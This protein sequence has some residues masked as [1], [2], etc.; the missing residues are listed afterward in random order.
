MVINTI[1]DERLNLKFASCKSLYR[2]P[3]C[4]IGRPT[5]SY[6]PNHPFLLWR[7]YQTGKGW[8]MNIISSFYIYVSNSNSMSHITIQMAFHGYVWQTWYIPHQQK[9]S[10]N[11]A[12]QLYAHYIWATLWPFAACEWRFIVYC[13]KYCGDCFCNLYPSANFTKSRP[14]IA[15]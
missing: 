3:W 10:K 13:V 12:L 4:G 7:I 5:W 9:Y 14:N 11:Y 6:N 1:W 8:F 15:Y 2:M